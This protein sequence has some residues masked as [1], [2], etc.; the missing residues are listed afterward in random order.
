MSQSKQFPSDLDAERVLLS[1]LMMMDNHNQC[2][3]FCSIIHTEYFFNPLHKRIFGAIS[4]L[5]NSGALPEIVSVNSHIGDQQVTPILGDIAA[6]AATTANINYYIERVAN[7]AIRRLAIIE[8]SNLQSSI[9]ATDKPREFLSEYNSKLNSLLNDLSLRDD[10]TTIDT[11]KDTIDMVRESVE[12]EHG[13]EV[14]YCIAAIDSKIKIFRKQIH[15]LG[16]RP[17][18]GKTAWALS[19]MFSQIRSG[20]KV[21]FF[22]G[23]SDRQELMMRLASIHSRIPYDLIINGFKGGNGSEIARF[24]SAMNFLREHAGHF[25]IYGLG[26]I[27]YAVDN[28]RIAA[29]RIAEANDGLDMIYADHLHN[30]RPPTHLKNAKRIEY[31]AENTRQFKLLN[32]EMDTAGTLLCQLN[33]E[34]ERLVRPNLTS[35]KETSTIEEESHVVSFLHREERDADAENLDTQWYSGKTRV[36]KPFATILN[37]SCRNAEFTGRYPHEYSG[38]GTQAC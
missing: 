23:E 24:Q 30:L 22:C 20:M 26:D 27:P 36:I 1:M 10:F 6:A 29:S 32:V 17:S 19:C 37:F 12:M 9:C 11:I 31:V 34:A 35:L 2:R 18:I 8:A 14:P 15:T 3:V 38:P 16:A 33:R 28:M 5:A 4:E 13:R 7:V 21:L 25:W